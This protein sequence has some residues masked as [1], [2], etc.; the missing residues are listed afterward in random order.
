MSKLLRL[1]QTSP[2]AYQLPSRIVLL[3]GFLLMVLVMFI[4]VRT[5]ERGHSVAP[6]ST[7]T[8]TSSQ[9]TPPTDLLP[10][11]VS[12]DNAGVNLEFHGTNP[13][14][15]ASP[16]KPPSSVRLASP[17]P[18]N[19]AATTPRGDN[20]IFASV[21]DG[22]RVTS[23][24]Q[25]AYYHVVNLAWDL[26]RTAPPQEGLRV[27]QFDLFRSPGKYRGRLIRIEGSLRRVR[28]DK[29]DPDPA[30]P[31]RPRPFYECAIQS[32]EAAPFIVLTF[33]NPM[34][35]GIMPHGDG[36]WTDAYF[37]KI[38]GYSD[39]KMQ[40]PLL[41]GYRLHAL[42][43]EAPLT[44]IAGV[45][46]GGFALLIVIVWFFLTRGRRKAEKLR[47]RISRE[48]AE[49][50]EIPEPAALPRDEKRDEKP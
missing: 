4:V 5:R 36:V 19:L 23:Q 27:L 37:F 21:L 22:H 2:S 15:T 25:Q 28:E 46:L 40:A 9:P 47:E 35:S 31:D 34:T 24:E 43:T 12:A 39:D 16:E 50:I 13:G 3:S 48:L 33:E 14:T 18:D 49:D 30:R 44:G 1:V 26:S 10:A 6:A 8:A 42:K 41:M 45:V 38:W 11:S 7:D 32:A 17:V 29:F 20:D